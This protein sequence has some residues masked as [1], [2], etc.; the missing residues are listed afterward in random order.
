MIDPLMEYPGYLLR[1]ASVAAM[2]DLADRLSV[3][4]LRPTEA[5][6]LLVIDANPGATLSDVG[7]LLRIASANMVPLIARLEARDLIDREPMDGRSQ[8]L[9]LAPLGRSLTQKIKDV[10]TEHEATLIERIPAGVRG[11]FLEALRTIWAGGSTAD[12][13]GSRRA[14]SAAIRPISEV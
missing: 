14:T 9:V 12:A 1:R 8:A 7:R 3:L 5:T 13:P 6:V 4:G 10:V 2:A 11:D